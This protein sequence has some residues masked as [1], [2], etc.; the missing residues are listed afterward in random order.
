MYYEINV[1]KNGSHYFA[2]AQRS[3]TNRAKCIEL[4]QDLME[5][6]PDSEGFRLS[7][8]YHPEV[9]SSLTLFESDDIVTIACHLETLENNLFEKRKRV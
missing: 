3:I 7:V 6:F 5:R 1:A 8:S 4:I 2:T 9:S